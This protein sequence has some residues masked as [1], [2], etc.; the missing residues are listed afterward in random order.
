MRE[1][2]SWREK[3]KEREEKKRRMKEREREILREIKRE[4]EREIKR[5]R[6]REITREREREREREVKEQ[7]KLYSPTINDVAGVVEHDLTL[8]QGGHRVQQPERAD[9]PLETRSRS[10]LQNSKIDNRRS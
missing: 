7:E 1:I 3:E 4:R 8:V 10:C 6:E 5:E 2:E 9:V